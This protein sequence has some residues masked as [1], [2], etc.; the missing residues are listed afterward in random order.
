MH[1]H[2]LPAPHRSL[3][4]IA[5]FLL[6]VASGVLLLRAPLAARLLR[7]PG[8]QRPR[9]SRCCWRGWRSLG[10]APPPSGAR[11]AGS[12]ISAAAVPWRGSAASRRR[13]LLAPLARLLAETGGERQAVLAPTTLRA[14]LDG[15]AGRVEESRELSRYLFALLIFLGLLGT[16]WGLLE[17]IA[18][19]SAV[20][21]EQPA[22][23]ESLAW[24]EGLRRGLE[25]PLAGM[26]TAFSTSLF[27]L[28][29]A[30]VLGF[31]DLLAS[32][33]QNRFLVALEDGLS[34]IARLPGGALAEA[35]S[36]VPSY[37]EALL[38]SVAESLDR[39][40]RLVAEGE[41]GRSE[42]GER[43]G[44]LG[45]RARRPARGHRRPGA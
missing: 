27:G 44:L 12:G 14:I 4:V 3:A 19:A 30:L 2:R 45:G 37:L 18:A 43:I 32:R 21:A 22:S 9:S 40:Q 34:A 26:A 6:A 25:R 1:T 31:L 36:P 13:W 10:G 41:R 20:I 16:F 23:G 11:R 35:E 8:F 5:L 38:A 42:L 15:V 17:T 29:G 28:A 24:F 7:Q 39:L 33:A